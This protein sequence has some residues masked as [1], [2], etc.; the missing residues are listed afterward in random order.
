MVIRNSDASNLRPIKTGVFTFF[1][2]YHQN[3]PFENISKF[4]FALFQLIG[5]KKNLNKKN[6]GGAFV[7]LFHLPS[8][9]YANVR[10]SSFQHETAICRN[11]HNTSN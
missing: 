1:S 5:T 9:N 6:I 10:V 4:L 3:N 8:P 7:P 11:P 2:L